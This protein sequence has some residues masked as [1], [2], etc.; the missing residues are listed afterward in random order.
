MKQCELYFRSV[1]KNT[2]K[3]LENMFPSLCLEQREEDRCPN[4]AVEYIVS[5]AGQKI[6]LCAEHYDQVAADGSITEYNH[7]DGTECEVPFTQ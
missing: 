6:F 1:L 5:L 4:A 7:L 2:D 3:V